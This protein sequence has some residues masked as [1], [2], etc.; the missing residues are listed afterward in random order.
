MSNF[1]DAYRPSTISNL[2]LRLPLAL[3]F[4]PLDSARK[5]TGYKYQAQ[6]RSLRPAVI[7]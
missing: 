3:L 6:A 1:H 7:E 4:P 5:H 2:P